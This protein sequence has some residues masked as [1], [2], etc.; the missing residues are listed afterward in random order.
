M[1]TK[2]EAGGPKD[3]GRDSADETPDRSCARPRDLRVVVLAL[4]VVSD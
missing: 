2:V 4:I 1:L 3:R